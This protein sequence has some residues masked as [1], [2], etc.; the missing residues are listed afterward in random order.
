[1]VSIFN[2]S[3]VQIADV[4]KRSDISDIYYNKFANREAATLGLWFSI[5]GT[6][7]S[8]HRW[9]NDST[10]PPFSWTRVQLLLRGPRIVDVPPIRTRLTALPKFALLWFDFMLHKSSLMK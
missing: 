6:V 4:S 8:I 3:L 2:H 9:E 10:N 7:R 1:L 5:L